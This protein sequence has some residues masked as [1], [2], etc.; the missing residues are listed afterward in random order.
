MSQWRPQSA[1]AIDLKVVL[2]GSSSVGKTSLVDRRVPRLAA[3]AARRV[4]LLRAPSVA[5]THPAARRC[6]VPLPRAHEAPRPPPIAAHAAGSSRYTLAGPQRRT[7]PH[8]CSY[9]NGVFDETPR[10]TI[11]AA[12]GARTV[13]VP[14]GRGGRCNFVLGIWDTAGAERFE[15]LSRVYYHGAGA[16]VICYDPTDA[17]SFEKVR[18][19]VRQ[20]QARVAAPPARRTSRRVA[21]AARGRA[22]RSKR[23]S[24]RYTL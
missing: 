20:L 15:S 10:N 24:A 13:Q 16:A 21:I 3:A 18:F 4:R 9:L 7:L 6:R 23:T 8:A 22:R 17:L 2:L 11:G 12:F 1:H 19:W 14:D 5:S